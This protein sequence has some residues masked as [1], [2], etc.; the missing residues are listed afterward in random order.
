[1]MLG[2]CREMALAQHWDLMLAQCQNMTSGRC[3]AGGH[4]NIGPTSKDDVG[5]TSRLTSVDIGP[6]LAHCQNTR[7]GDVGSADILI[8]AQ[9][10]KMMLGQRQ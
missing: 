6:T 10:R 9:R 1:M 8:L 4:F 5:P 2:Q 7:R 3:W